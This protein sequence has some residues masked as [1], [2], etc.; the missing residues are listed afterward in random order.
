VNRKLY[1]ARCVHDLL[2]L[3]L[4]TAAEL[5]VVLGLAGMIGLPRFPSLVYLP[6]WVITGYRPTLSPSC[7]R[8]R[9]IAQ[10][11]Y[12]YHYCHHRLN[13]HHHLLIYH[14]SLSSTFPPTHSRDTPANYPSCAQAHLSPFSRSW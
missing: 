14:L 6:F 11:A 2:D 7:Q 3:C 8:L 13:S 12:I 1:L 4:T 10:S 9:L 5:E